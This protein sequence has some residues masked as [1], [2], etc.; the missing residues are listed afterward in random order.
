[1]AAHGDSRT[2][3]VWFWPRSWPSTALRSRDALADALWGDFPPSSASKVVQ[4]CVVRL[5]KLLGQDAIATT[6]AGYALRARAESVDSQRF[7]RLVSKARECLAAGEPDR[8]AY[9]VEQALGLWRGAPLTDL[10]E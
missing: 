1:M 4:G 6:P 8:T 5:R 10:E 7:A 2:G 3:T 9:L